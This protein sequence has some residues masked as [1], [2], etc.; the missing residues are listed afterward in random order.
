MELTVIS[1]VWP[2]FMKAG[3]TACTDTAATFFSC[4][5]TFGGTVTPSCANMLVRDCTVKGAWLV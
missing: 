5:V 4:G 3:S 1:M 2:G